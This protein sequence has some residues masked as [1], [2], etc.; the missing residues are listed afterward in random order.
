MA[1]YRYLTTDLL[2]GAVLSEMPLGGVSMGRLMNGAGELRGQLK[3]SDARVRRAFSDAYSVPRKCGLVAL[4]DAVPIWGGVISTRRH[5]VETEV[6][7]FTANEWWSALQRRKVTT[8]VT[9]A[10]Q[11]VESAAALIV[12][13]AQTGTNGALGLTV[14]GTTGQTATGSVLAADRKWAADALTALLKGTG[15]AGVDFETSVAYSG[16]LLLPYLHVGS[17]ALGRDAATS[18]LSSAEPL[19]GYW[20]EDGTAWAT[21][22]YAAASG[23]SATSVTAFV[24]HAAAYADGWPRWDAEFNATAASVDELTTAATSYLAARLP[25]AAFATGLEVRATDPDVSL[26]QLGDTISVTF[27]PSARFPAGLFTPARIT[28]WTLSPG[29]EGGLD[30]LKLEVGEAA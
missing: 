28:G 15:T 22:V 2:T 29:E 25:G 5:Q 6:T 4:L 7:S 1:D 27:A 24:E 16:D 20:S 8:D 18:G 30:T 17:P 21:G 9:W 13:D 26:I 19:T 11:S 12:A 10:N 23:N 3:L 14:T